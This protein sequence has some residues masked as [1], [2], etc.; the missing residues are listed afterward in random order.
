MRPNLKS[1]I[2]PDLR[3]THPMG[4]STSAVAAVSIGDLAIIGASSVLIR[5]THP[6]NHFVGIPGRITSA[7]NLRRSK[8]S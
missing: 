2:R 1:G 3:L 7:Q 6:N 5:V 8:T 4:H